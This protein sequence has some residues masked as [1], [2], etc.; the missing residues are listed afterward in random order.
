MENN[1]STHTF[2][3]EVQQ[4]LH[5]LVYSLYEHK[6]VF[7][8]ELISNAADALGKMRFHLVSGQEVAD[9]ELPLEIRI[10]ALKEGRVLVVEDTGVGMTRQE[11]MD[12]LGT[13]AHSGTQAFL[14][15]MQEAGG[16]QERNELIGRFGVG[17]YASFMVAREVRV[18]T[19][20]WRPGE[21]ACLWSSAG[22]NQ[23]VIEETGDR[24]RGTRIELHLKE[25]EDEFLDPSRIEEVLRRHSRFVPFP[26]VVEG[27]PLEQVDA[28][29]TRPRQEVTDEDRTA[30]YRSLGGGGDEPLSHLQVSSDAPLPFSALLF[31][32]TF[33]PENL[34]FGK[35]DPGVDLYSRKVMIQKGSKALLPEYLRFVRGV[36]DAED[37]PLNVSRETVQRDVRLETLKRFLTK[38]VLEHLAG[39]KKDDPERYETFWTSFQRFVREGVVSDFDNREKLAGLLRFRSLR[40]GRE[41][42]VDLDAYLAGMKEGQKAI[43]YVTGMDLD[44]LQANPA[45]EVFRRRD[46]DVLTLTDP[47]DEVVIDHLRTYR[48]LPFE[49]AE[50]ADLKLD[51]PEGEAE[52]REKPEGMDGFLEYLKTVLGESVAEVR[53]SER[54]TDSPCMLVTP[55][56]GPSMQM[57]KVLKMVQKDYRYAPRVLEVNAGHP[58]IGEMIRIHRQK[59]DSGELRRMALLLRDGQW[60]R[61]GIL[62]RVDEIIPRLQELMLA[63]ARHLERD[64]S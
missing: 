49:S 36:V 60:L 7:L 27:K 26:L 20:S 62:D 13:I 19:R 8:R 58:L 14:R 51:E 2:Q 42:W 37:L 24:E 17:F 31:L 59:P 43:Y 32:P 61:E 45:L 16:A 33:N 18:M 22:D 52:G 29:W 11:L 12:N 39:L 41:Q 6:E 30:F 28:I 50:G 1:R 4:L 55:K 46:W 57:E 25:G 9:R 64:S 3:S 23:Y 63:A 56:D 35:M 15:Q 34:G 5:L 10:S 54:L 53:V 40:N 48:E 38:K 44:T 21:P 47:L